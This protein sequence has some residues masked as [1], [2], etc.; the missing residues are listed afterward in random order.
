MD[1]LLAVSEMFVPLCNQ[2]HL[3]VKSQTSLFHENT[4]FPRS[5]STKQQQ[6]KLLREHLAFSAFRGELFIFTTKLKSL[7]ERMNYPFKE[8]KNY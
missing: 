8:L 1:T 7:E 5:L 4:K 2:T 6:K 3:G